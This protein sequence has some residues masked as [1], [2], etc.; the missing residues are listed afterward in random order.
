MKKRSSILLTAIVLTLFLL[1]TGQGFCKD[2]KLLF[3]TG[4]ISGTF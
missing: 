4:G 2:E 1:T 3:A